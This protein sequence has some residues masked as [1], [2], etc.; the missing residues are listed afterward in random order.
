MAIAVY[1]SPDSLARAKYDEVVAH[2]TEAGQNE[3]AGRLH[4]SSFGPD[5]HVMV[6]EVW[7]SQEAF[8][9]YGPTLMPVLAESGVNPG[10]P[11]VMPVHNLIQ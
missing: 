1:F 8:E 9:A 10:E 11:Q 4:H 6:Y 7:E 5:D 2:L 3:P